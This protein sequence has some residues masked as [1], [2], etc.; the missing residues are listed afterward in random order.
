MLENYPI[1]SVW[2]ALVVTTAFA[3]LARLL[4]GVSSSGAVAGGVISFLLYM[5]GGPGAFAALVTVFVLTWV[6]TRIGYQR[7]ARLGIAEKR[8]GRKASQVLAN[9][10]VSAA[11]GL[12]YAWSSHPAYLVAA[13]AAL[14]EAA[15]DTVSSELGQASSST[16]R[17]VTTWER[18]AAGTDGAVSLP[19][20]VG[21]ITAALLVSLV[22]MGTGLLSPR[23]MMLAV[24]AAIAGTIMDSF[25]GAS[26]ER[27]RILNNDLVNFLSTFTAGAI[28]FLLT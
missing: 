23:S 3:I 28:A 16:A 19:G 17:L 18:V 13:A 20:T 1:H 8:D 15:A 26:L 7:K 21:G 24:L 12:L 4:R 2:T 25:L 14:A 27:H 10:G 9:L 5:C 11:C 22:C 6:A